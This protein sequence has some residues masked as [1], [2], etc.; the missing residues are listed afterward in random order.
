MP[1]LYPELL[2]NRI[3]DITLEDLRALGVKGLLLDVDNTLA[4][5]GSQVLDPAVEDF[6][7]FA[8]ASIKLEGYQFHP[9]DTPIPVAV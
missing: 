5:H 6:Y 1:L 4:L 2:R 8:P 9:L 3:T 7:R